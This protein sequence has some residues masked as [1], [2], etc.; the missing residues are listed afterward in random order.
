MHDLE[1]C[2]SRAGYVQLPQTDLLFGYYLPVNKF[3]LC[4]EMSRYRSAGMT[5]GWHGQQGQT[6][7]M[8]VSFS[9]AARHSLSAT[10]TAARLAPAALRAACT[11]LWLCLMASS[12]AV[13]PAPSTAFSCT[14]CTTTQHAAQ[15]CTFSDCCCYA[16]ACASG[17]V[18]GQQAR[19][20]CID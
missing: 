19:Q 3:V 18:H 20:P 1:H 2:E 5:A 17:N 11:S 8:P 4:G 12:R 16:R 6:S 15:S 14:P 9:A 13:L 10:L 7:K